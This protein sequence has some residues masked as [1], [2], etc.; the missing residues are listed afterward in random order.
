MDDGSVNFGDLSFAML[1]EQRGIKVVLPQM[2]GAL[3]IE[4]ISL[5]EDIEELG[6]YIMFV[7]NRKE[8]DLSTATRFIEILLTCYCEPLTSTRQ[9]AQLKMELGKIKR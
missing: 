9:L 8:I 6:N 7:V 2:H 1:A 3:T 4:F 5:V